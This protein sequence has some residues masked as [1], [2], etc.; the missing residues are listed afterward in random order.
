[1]SRFLMRR[2]L[3]A[4]TAAGALCASSTAAA[5]AA[6]A[7]ALP[8]GINAPYLYLGWGHPQNPVGIMKA[9]GIKQFT[10]SF[11]TSGGTCNPKWDGSRPLRGGAEEKAIKNIRAAGGDVVASFGGWS[12]NKLGISCTT[13]TAL[14]RAYQKV[15][16]AY[17]LKAIDVNIEHTEDDKPVVRQR[18]VDALKKVKAANPSLK[19][20][21]TF[22]GRSDGPVHTI[23]DLIKRAGAAHLPVTGWN[24]MAFNFDTPHTMGT[25]TMKSADGVKNA[26]AAAY[27]V[28]SA[29]AYRHIGISTMNGKTDMKGQKISVRNFRTMLRYAQRHHLARF[30]FWSVN[31]DRSCTRGLDA[32]SCSGVKQAQYDYTKVVARYHG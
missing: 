23:R 3:V 17:R 5:P 19:V 26:V 15:I 13:P 11:I 8:V 12:G 16:S 7:A 2:A 21:I 31:R 6:Q 27:G 14:A 10:L 9:T 4:C 25:T 29:T 22:S 32:D 28:K 1:M 20:Y 30:T 18:I 24:V